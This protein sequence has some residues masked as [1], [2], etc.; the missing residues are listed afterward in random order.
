MHIWEGDGKPCQS[1]LVC[2]DS[3]DG[4][5]LVSQYQWAE[6]LWWSILGEKWQA[7]IVSLMLAYPHYLD[8]E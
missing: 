4:E 3:G 1:D 7:K 6:S 2:P 8:P 5:T